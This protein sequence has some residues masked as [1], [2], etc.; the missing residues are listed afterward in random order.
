MNFTKCDKIGNH[1]AS[2]VTNNTKKEVSNHAKS[3][4]AAKNNSA[5]KHLRTLLLE[6]VTSSVL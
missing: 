1:D 6:V 5:A 4:D 2:V 3:T